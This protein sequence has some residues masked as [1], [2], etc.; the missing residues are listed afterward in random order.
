MTTVLQRT[1]FI[2][3][4]LEAIIVDASAQ[5]R[6]G[7][8]DVAVVAEYAEAMEQGATFPPVVL[9]HDGGAEYFPA[10][11]FHRIAAAK[12]MG[13]STIFA[14]VRHGNH[15]DAILHAVGSNADHGLRRTQADKR[16]AVE[17]L[18]HDPEWSR[19][20]DRKIAEA[21]KVDHKTVAKI[22]RELTGEIPTGRM[23]GVRS[24]VVEQSPPASPS[25]GGS[26]IA[27]LLATLTDDALIA[28]CQRRGMEVVQ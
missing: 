13:R 1:P 19:L 10:D 4:A 25:Q 28:E 23:N 14:D 3:I 26:M 7:G 12:K 27:R 18:L 22:R 21:A 8:T 16:N 11:G 24:G 20:S 5:I 6:V 9:F 17:T 15:R 2:E